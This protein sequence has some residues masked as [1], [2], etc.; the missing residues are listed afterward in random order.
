MES[1][2]N[3]AVHS[4]FQNGRHFF[5]QKSRDDGCLFLSNKQARRQKRGENIFQVLSA[6]IHPTDIL[7]MKILSGPRKQN[8]ER[9]AW[10]RSLDNSKGKFFGLPYPKEHY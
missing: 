1:Q 3:L 6:R 9:V 5:T 2:L 4:Y 8:L 10:D 7:P